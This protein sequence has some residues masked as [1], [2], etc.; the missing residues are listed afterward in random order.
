MQRLI[1]V[2]LR[3]GDI[4]FQP[5]GD[6]G[7]AGVNIAKDLIAVQIG[8]GNDTDRQQIQYFIKTL[9]FGHHLLVNGIEMLGTAENAEVQMFIRQDAVDIDDDL[10]DLFVSFTSLVFY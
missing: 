5:A 3:H 7:I 6:R 9:V 10:A 1:H 8:L 2:E 4:V